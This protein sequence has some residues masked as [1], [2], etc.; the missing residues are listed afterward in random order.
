MLRYGRLALAH[1]DF[2]RFLN[3]FEYRLDR[4]F[5]PLIS[6]RMVFRPEPPVRALDVR[7]GRCARQLQSPVVFVEAHAPSPLSF[8]NR[9]FIKKT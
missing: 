3:A 5:V 6:V 7:L 1:D 4:G 2:E 8:S 9:E